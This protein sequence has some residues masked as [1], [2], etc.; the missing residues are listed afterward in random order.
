MPVGY[1]G[2]AG[3]RKALGDGAF[4]PAL[5]AIGLT[6]YLGLKTRLGSSDQRESGL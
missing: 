6:G 4:L 2:L 1:S 3:L 5:G